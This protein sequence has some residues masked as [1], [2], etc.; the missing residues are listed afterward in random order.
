MSLRLLFPQSLLVRR[1]IVWVRRGVCPHC[2]IGYVYEGLHSRVTQ[3]RPTTRSSDNVFAQLWRKGDDFRGGNENLA[4]WYLHNP[5]FRRGLDGK[6]LTLVQKPFL[7]YM[8]NYIELA[9]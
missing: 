8:I 3:S 2:F 5:R 9:L 6:L 4:T 7:L 1:T